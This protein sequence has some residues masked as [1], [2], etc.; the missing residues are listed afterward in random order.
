MK[1]PLHA[2]LLAM[3]SMVPAA[4][5]A[6]VQPLPEASHLQA[7]V[8]LSRPLLRGHIALMAEEA[9]RRVEDSTTTYAIYG[10]I[11]FLVLA[12]IGGAAFAM[13]RK[14]AEPKEGA[15]DA[16]EAAA[17]PSETIVVAGEEKKDAGSMDAEKLM[18]TV[19][20]RAVQ[21]VGPKLAKA[22]AVKG[23]L[24][25]HVF[26]FSGKAQAFMAS[27]LYSTVGALLKEM[28][29]EEAMVLFGM[30]SDGT[31]SVPPMSVLL[32][33]MLSPVILSVSFFIHLSQVAVVLIPVASLC[34]WAIW[35][36]IT[37]GTLYGCAVPGLWLWI[38]AIGGLAAIL[39]LAHIAAMV[40]I[41]QGQSAIR[42]KADEMKDE[43]VEA[44]GDGELSVDEIRKLFLVSS[45]LLEH[46]LKVEDDMR[47]SVWRSVI[48]LGTIAWFILTI[49]NFFI[50]LVYTFVPGVV[51]FHASAAEVAGDD[52]CGAWASVLTARLTCV[53]ALLFV[54]FNVISMIQ[55]ISDQ[56][57]TSEGYFKGILESAKKFDQSSIG[58][59]VAQ[60]MVKAFLLRGNSE[61]LASHI[62]NANN[63]TQGLEDERDRLQNLKESL[64]GRIGAHKAEASALK[65]EMGIVEEEVQQGPSWADQAK[66]AGAAAVEEAKAQ[67]AALE[68][69]T[70]EELEVLL[71]KIMEAAEQVRNSEALKQAMEQ[72][73]QAKALAEEKA[74]QAKALAE[75]PEALKAAMEEAKAA[76]AEGMEQAKAAAQ[77]GMAQAQEAAQAGMA[78]AQE[79]A[80]KVM[81]SEAVQQAK[82][83]AEALAS[84]DAVQQAKAQAEQAVAK[85]K[86]AATKASEQLK[87]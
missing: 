76:A 59:P 10:G 13:T 51:A 3:V 71:N 2:A 19:A 67:A 43:I 61:T 11:G 14:P 75:D 24:E 25:N 6:A 33:G 22:N 31:I 54:I 74:A 41:K 9:L 65:K 83:Q 63:V 58:V 84:S 79:A 82:A 32:A 81:A 35:H 8:E 62:A 4:L 55:Y 68:K 30:G 7:D 16:K 87:K 66:E 72:A 12:G 5:A 38:F 21:M 26:G 36:D 17:A 48:G 52:F 27:E 78:Q 45:V 23:V 85:G 28:E 70:R 15:E 86:E 20:K 29:A 69:M 77:E 1:L 46:A 73:E 37:E 47:R 80:D 53:L 60:V 64:E 56:L 40:M 18:K 39:A 50:V 57:V 42:A 34:A 49:W 44:V